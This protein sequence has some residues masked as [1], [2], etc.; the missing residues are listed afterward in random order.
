MSSKRAI[1]ALKQ[2]KADEE[3]QIHNQIVEALA[4]IQHNKTEVIGLKPARKVTVV[5]LAKEAGVSR[6]SLYGNHR[7]L[8]KRLDKINEKR[9]RTPSVVRKEKEEKQA[10]DAELLTQLTDDKK[11]LARENYGLQQRVTEL[12]GMVEALRAQLGQTSNVRSL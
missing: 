8:L 5:D 11:K 12:E 7:E 10:R 9:G 1:D 3:E 4:R 6:G 2:G